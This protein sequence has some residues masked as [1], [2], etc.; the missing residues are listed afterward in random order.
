MSKHEQSKA[1]EIRIGMVA[2]DKA[3]K[4][5]KVLLERRVRHPKYGKYVRRRTVLQ[6]HD[7]NQQAHVGDRVAISPCRPI[8]KTKHWRLVRV[9]R[10]YGGQEPADSTGGAD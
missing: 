5:V 10:S 4:T 6:V 1:A 2:S 9:L 7:E 3:G 8:S